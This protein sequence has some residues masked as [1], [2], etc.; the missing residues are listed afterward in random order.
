MQAIIDE[1]ADEQAARWA[2]YRA[3]WRRDRRGE[4]PLV[5]VSCHVE[6]RARTDLQ[7][8]AVAS[9]P[10]IAAEKSVVCEAWPGNL[11]PSPAERKTP[12][13]SGMAADASCRF[14]ATDSA[15]VG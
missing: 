9:R 8:N 15:I 14:A 6:H 10:A 4:D 2:T 5:G 3:A 13:Q 1:R 12:G 11:P 7:E